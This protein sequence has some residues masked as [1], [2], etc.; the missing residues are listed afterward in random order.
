MSGCLR[1]LLCVLLLIGIAGPTSSLGQ[2]PP[3]QLR[4]LEGHEASVYAVAYA[5]DGKTIVGVSIDG[6]VNVW[7]REDGSLIRR[8]RDHDGAALAVAVSPDGRRLVSGSVNGH[9]V[10]RDLP[11]RHPHRVIPDLAGPTRDVALDPQGRWL[12][13][14]EPSK[15]ARLWDLQ[16]GKAVHK[17]GDVSAELSA[18]SIVRVLKP[19]KKAQ[20]KQGAEGEAAD[21][22]EL[23][24][25]PRPQFVVAAAEDGSIRGWGIAKSDSVGVVQ[26]TPQTSLATDPQGNFLIA[27]GQDGMLRTLLWPPQ[28]ETPLPGHSDQVTVACFSPDGERI[29]TGTLNSAVQLFNRQGKQQHK[30]EGQAGQVH[31]AAFSPDG[32]RIATGNEL[33]TVQLWQVGEDAPAGSLFGHAGTVAGLAFHPTA[34]QLAT[35]GADGTVRTWKFPQPNQTLAGNGAAV[36][37]L[38]VSSDGSLL[39]SASAD[40]RL[41]VWKAGNKA[42][43]KVVAEIEGLR[44]VTIGPENKQ[45]AAGDDKG[46][47]HL[48]S[49]PKGEKQG[50]IVAHQGPVSGLI[51]HP[52][53][54]QLVSTGHDGLLK[55]WNVPLPPQTVLATLP[56]AA[57]AVAVDGDGSL[58]LAAGAEGK[59]ET[60]NLKTGKAGKPLE[61]SQEAVGAIAVSPD[62]A[63]AAIGRVSGEAELWSLADR[64][65]VGRVA[66]HEKAVLDVALHPDQPQ[67]ATSGEDGT[68]RVWK[69]PAAPRTIAQAAE[70]Q[71]AVALSADGKRALVGGEDG[72]AFVTGTA[73]EAEPQKLAAGEE[74]LRAVALQPDGNQGLTGDDAGLIRLWDLKTGEQRL[75]IRGHQGPVAGLAFHPQQ[76]MAVSAGS[77]GTVKLWQLN[78]GAPAAAAQHE[79]GVAALAVSND[80]SLVASAGPGGKLRLA[81][82]AGKALK[83]IDGL[84]SEVSALALSA[85]NQQLA[86]ALQNGRIRVFATE[87]GK[88]T[89]LLGGHRGQATGVAFHATGGQLASVGEDGALRIWKLGAGPQEL[90]GHN[91]A[92]TLVTVSPNGQWIASGGADKTVRL[93]KAADGSLVH[94]LGLESPATALAWRADNQT[95]ISGEKSGKSRVWNA[96]DGK[97]Q[98]QFAVDG[99]SISATLISADGKTALAARGKSILV[100]NTE[101]GKQAATVDIHKEAVTSLGWVEGDLIAS[102]SADGRVHLW[103]LVETEE[104]EGEEKQK[105]IEA[106]IAR[107]VNPGSAVVDLAVSGDRK[108][109]AV[110]GADQTIKL[111]QVSDGK[112]TGSISAGAP[113]GD[114]AFSRDNQR[115]AATLG[116]GEVR[117]FKTS[118]EPLDFFHLG[119]AQPASLDFAGDHQTLVAAAG[120][121]MVRMLPPTLLHQI[122]ASEQPLTAVA[123]SPDGK[124][125]VAAAAD[126][127]TQAFNPEN[128]QSVRSFGGAKSAVA[129]LAISADNKL[130]LAAADKQVHRWDLSNGKAADPLAHEAATRA[131]DISS[132]GQRIV[133]GTES[134]EVRVWDAATG[135][136]MERFAQHG[137]SAD[138]VAFLGP[139]PAVV[140]GGADGAVWRCPLAATMAVAAHEGGATAVRFS[141]DGNLILSGGADKTVK[142]LDE[143]GKVVRQMTGSEEAIRGLAATATEN[144][145][146][147]ASGDGHVYQWR[148]DNG[149]A[150]GKFPLGQPATAVSYSAD[151]TRLAVACQDQPLLHILRSADG[152]VLERVPL[153]APGRDVVMLPEGAGIAVA[154]EKGAHIAS[155]SLLQLLEGHEGAVTCVQFSPQG[156]SLFSGSA[157]KTIRQWNLADGKQLRAFSGSGG[158]ITGLDVTADGQ[159][160]VSAGEDKQL[161][162]WNVANGQAVGNIEHPAALRAVRL[163]AEATRVATSGDDGIVRLWDRATGRLLQQ[164]VGHEGGVVALAAASTQ[165]MFLTAGADKTVRLWRPA[166]DRL[167]VADEGKLHDLALLPDGQQIATAGDD[168]QVKLWDREGKPVRAFGGYPSAVRRVVVSPDGKLIAAGGDPSGGQKDVL[169]WQ[170]AD[171]K[172]LHKVTVPEGVIS[173]AVDEQG[174]LSVGSTDKRVRVYNSADARLREELP[175]S[176]VPHDIRSLGDGR[177]LI[178]GNEKSVLIASHRLVKV[179]DAHADGASDLAFTP[180]GKHLVTCGA[181]APIKLW[182]FSDGKLAAV[183]AGNTQASDDVAV[184]LDGK[185]VYAGGRDKLVRAWDITQSKADGSELAPVATFQHEAAIRSVAPAADGRKL[186]VAEDSGA[187]LVWHLA[188]GKLLEKLLGHNGVAHSVDLADDGA[189]ILSGGA[190]KTAR[191]RKAS[192]IR[193]RQAHEGAVVS[194]AISGDGQRLF[195]AAQSNPIAGWSAE[196]LEPGTSLSGASGPLRKIVVSDDGTHL[197]AADKQHLRLWQ[198]GQEAPL[199]SIELPAEAVDVAIGSGGRKLTVATAD[200][201][202]RHY[203]L[204][205]SD[206]KPQLALNYESRAA[207]Q[208]FASVALAADNHL[209]VTTSADK[210]IGLWHAASAEPLGQ[211]TGHRGPIFDLRYDPGGKWIGSAS[212]DRTARIWDVTNL[213]EPAFVLDG[214]TDQVSS[215]DFH[216]KGQEVVTASLDRTLAGWT[217]VDLEIPA[218]EQKNADGKQDGEQPAP[219]GPQKFAAGQRIW[220]ISES[221][222][223]KPYTVRY[224]PQG[225]RLLSG[226]VGQI[227]QQ[228]SRSNGELADSGIGHNHAL[229]RAIYNAEGNRLATIDYGAKLHVW[230]AKSGGLLFHQQLPAA[231]GYSIAYAP[232]GTELAAGTSDQRVI[233][234]RIPENAR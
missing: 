112:Q 13:T 145:V 122:N 35:A 97:Q 167:V 169:L 67:W 225:S 70:P 68:V 48:L 176:E 165:Q 130:L 58:A 219:A 216:P 6:W 201:V 93:W 189:T 227:W 233:L 76:E 18:I 110:A 203:A 86:V 104:G 99:G 171:A 120:D 40:N 133:T 32:K 57:A 34:E 136:V 55:L 211:L 107:S 72:T 129:D 218:Q 16:E 221:L 209:L 179:W 191:L 127:A 177:L 199:A 232:D 119:D 134:G 78:A 20:D 208:P 94:S 160:L 10:R 215:L 173:L 69:H 101:D 214:H 157:D 200:H 88:P 226:G 175:L 77:D 131:V 51:W 138:A 184:S 188:S 27:G 229:Y 83:Q 149:Q 28:P 213:A 75:T 95:L 126:G 162:T 196:T 123:Y 121:N 194:L 59:V 46:R 92:V 182:S 38:A 19:Q 49:L 73:G 118:G 113:L 125:V 52:A 1:R 17:Y 231:A 204:T 23:P 228:W 153:A 212:G 36:H 152:R 202:V 43:G 64:T 207:E 80:G 217:L 172:Q 41:V 198:T 139:T 66:G 147:A 114:V 63:G 155:A 65:R 79:G 33:G 170:V 166:A 102:G 81:D 163:A 197:A 159:Q 62:G 187:V 178:G 128:G 181:D 85:D 3:P 91:E 31:S 15:T 117:V 8:T 74:A 124:Q 190:D 140:S 206:G 26:T 108:T 98:A 2:D 82:A 158:T 90:A 195:S 60:W 7:N 210:T 223:G 141:P 154:D 14:A 9:I 47:I 37:R 45:I 4:F 106:E 24:L 135:I 224:D 183:L 87:T 142:V 234:L 42:E 109:I 100:W 222:A 193:A 11:V 185:R 174:R 192:V 50:E 61:G 230:D 111:F 168:K 12:A 96:S 143:S 22:A 150:A 53:G 56:E 180:D 21:E 205:Q 161:R 39:A 156:K 29:L 151:G 84:D 116:D 25:V 144:R 146:S 132:D 103:N 54:K 148:F 186:A 5:P 71:N 105:K 164:F 44:V 137:K 220:Q 89:L 30:F 115:I